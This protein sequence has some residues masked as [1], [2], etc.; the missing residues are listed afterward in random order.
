VPSPRRR[1]QRPLPRKY[2]RRRAAVLVALLLVAGGGAFAVVS[3]LSSP[4]A[5][6]GPAPPARMVTAWGVQ[7]PRSRATGGDSSLETHV[8]AP[9]RSTTT[10]SSSTTTTTSA[11]VTTTSEPPRTTSTSPSTT[12]TTSCA[13]ALPAQLASSGGSKQL[14]SVEAAGYGTTYATLTAWSLDGDCW[15]VASG[16]FEARLGWSGLEPAAEKREGDGATPEGLYGF[17][18]VMYGNQAD[19]GVHYPYHQL[20][21]GDWWDED[22]ASSDYNLFEHW[23]CGSTPP[24]AEG[25]EGSGSEALWTETAAYPSFAV[26]GYNDA[27]VA[28]RG[29]AIFLHYGL[30]SPTAGCVST[31]EPALDEILDWLESQDSPA[32]VIGTAADIASF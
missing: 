23:A 25:S 32:I 8:S 4:R 28:G 11:A 6:A 30:A 7:P 26:I 5:S 15:R 1:Y 12:T 29:S 10:S 22:P 20:V 13:G 18:A 24:F 21:C 16:P 31:G 14:V 3:G 2:L 19:P 9:A 27:R 17:G